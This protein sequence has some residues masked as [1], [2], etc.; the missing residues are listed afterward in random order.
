V[1]P[2]VEARLLALGLASVP[3]VFT[4]L[5]AGRI[6]NWATVAV[7]TS[8]LA[9]SA[10]YEGSSGLLSAF[11]GAIAGLAVFI[12][13]YLAGGM[14]GGDIKLMAACGAVVGFGGVLLSAVLTA[15]LGAVIAVGAL[16]F[17]RLRHERRRTIPYAPAIVAG[18]LLTLLSRAV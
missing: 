13:F 9:V 10:V 8:G 3:I 12:V 14:G 17:S 4:D 11:A 16:V 5:R 1:A 18:A 6:P 7:L 2:A 15:I